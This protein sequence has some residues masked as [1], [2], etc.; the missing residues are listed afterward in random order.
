VSENAPPF[1]IVGSPRS[2]TTLLRVIL[3][4]HPEIAIPPESHFIPRLWE[5]R[6]RYGVEDRIEDVEL[7][8]QDLSS[9]GRFREWNLPIEAVESRISRE[10]LTF[11]SALE[12][13]YLEYAT[14][15]GKERWGDK[16]PKYINEMP[17]LSRVFPS[18]RFVHIIRDG[19]DVS[20]SLVDLGK[21]HRHAAS[22]AYVWA[23]T[24]KRGR[25]VGVRLGPDRYTEIR[26]E[27]ILESPEEE[28][29]R[30]SSFLGFDFDP[31]M[32]CDDGR[33][34][35]RVPGS[36]H[37]QH[38]RL[39]LPPTKGLRDWRKDMTDAQMA[40]CEAV[41]GDVLDGCGYELSH[42]EVPLAER[43][44]AWAHVGRFVGGELSRRVM[45][46]RRRRRR[47][48]NHIGGEENLLE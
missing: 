26:Y 1:F 18:A 41:A 39:S 15:R 28:I 35:S 2:G 21:R 4:R 6:R 48:S 29:G 43:A 34:L 10:G 11:G 31:A 17:L 44:A 16:T 3:D 20:L 32:L 46:S 19:R 14:S 12:A 27:D 24:V 22:G 36:R 25:N 38:T 42:R 5:G 45:R 23:R 30:L 7:F 37:H 13:V 47:R 8:M 9:E 33:A 40:E